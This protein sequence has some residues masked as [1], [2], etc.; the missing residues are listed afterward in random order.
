MK[1]G[2]VSNAV[3]RM[4]IFCLVAMVTTTL[5][6]TDGNVTE[7]I[8]SKE[9]LCTIQSVTVSVGEDE[10]TLTGGLEPIVVPDSMKWEDFLGQMKIEGNTLISSEDCTAGLHSGML[11]YL[12]LNDDW[13]KIIDGN[14]NT[15]SRYEFDDKGYY[16]MK[17][18]FCYGVTDQ[19]PAGIYVRFAKEYDITY[20]LAGGSFEGAAADTYL[21]GTGCT[22]PTPVRE[23]Y[24]FTG[25]TGTDLAN[26][27]MDVVI[28]TDAMGDR[29]Y[30]ATWVKEIDTCDITL[31]DGDV[32]THTGAE[33]KPA[34]T[35]KNGDVT[36][37]EGTDYTVAY[38]NNINVATKDAT[39]APTV[40]ITGKGKYTGSK[41][42]TFTIESA[43][44]EVGE[45]QKDKV[46]KATYKVTKS[47]E[48]KME[49]SYVK[50][51]SKT[52]SVSIPA[53][54]TLADGTTAKVTSVAAK[55]FKGNTKIQTVT[56]GKNVK[57][58]GKEAFSG[59]KNLKKVKSAKNVTSIGKNAFANCKNLT[60]VAMGSKVT[61]IG[62][63]AFY[64]CTKLTKITI[65]KNV[66]SIGK[67]AFQG[68]KKLKSITINTKKLTKK[69][70][71]KNAFKGIPSD[72]KINVPNSKVKAYK[73]ILRARGV[74]KK[75][76][77][78]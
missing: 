39:N 71:K 78:K 63:K 61:A 7:A 44:P 42:L 16:D 74:S 13:A 30:T 12:N 35:V 10:Y 75:A 76:T 38:S 70:V 21:A 40:T 43:L 56:I 72:A 32:Y 18:V 48:G 20:D 60:S 66:K 36:L 64:K 2:R 23:G 25:W 50:P 22:L 51:T 41:A 67:S 5:L 54:V 8:W 26:P 27:T 4:I 49:V 68:C 53:T 77:I 9:E 17:F 6:F 34:V 69:N 29:S 59:C 1:K 14:T 31:N 45:S 28:P 62:E 15:A 47:E 73:S 3:Q 33:I 65:P 58:I 11:G 19:T 55:A 24:V 57:T 46:G 37:V 52:K